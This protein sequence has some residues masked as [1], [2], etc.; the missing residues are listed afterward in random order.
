MQ[1]KENF[2][3]DTFTE[4]FNRFAAKAYETLLNKDEFK[5]NAQ[6]YH[7]TS[8]QK[9]QK[10]IEKESL[11]AGSIYMLNDPNELVHGYSHFL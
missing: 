10:I 4:L 7:Y 8:L 6:L 9:F 1:K 5:K 11:T 2:I 3:F